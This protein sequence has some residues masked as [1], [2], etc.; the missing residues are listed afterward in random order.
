MNEIFEIMIMQSHEDADRLI[1]ELKNN[2]D[3]NK[4]T[5]QENSII[6]YDD[7]NLLELDKQRVR[8]EVEKYL[9]EVLR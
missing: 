7:N 6:E 9:S 2:I 1:R 4:D 8:E 3:I 5:F